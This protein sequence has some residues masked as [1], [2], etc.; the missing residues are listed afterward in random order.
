MRN[1]FREQTAE[2]QGHERAGGRYSK[3]QVLAAGAQIR[4]ESLG[5]AS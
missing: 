4:P 1:V 5:K 3:S 2:G